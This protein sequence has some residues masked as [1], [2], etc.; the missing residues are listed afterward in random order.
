M[1]PRRDAGGL[2]QVVALSV[3]THRFSSEEVVI[4]SDVFAWVKPGDIVALFPAD[5]RR[6]DRLA[7]SVGK[8]GV[9]ASK[10]GV[11]TL[12]VSVLKSIA[13]RFGLHSMQQVVVSQIDPQQI[14]LDSLQLTFDSQFLSR[15]VL[16]RI[17]QALEGKC[18]YRGQ[19]LTVL[20]HKLRVQHMF[21]NG[22]EI[23]SG[24][25][26]S[27]TKVNFR[28][29]SARIIWLVQMS[30]EMWDF[31]NDGDIFFEKALKTFFEPCFERWAKLNAKHSLTVIFYT[32]TI[33][34][35]HSSALSLNRTMHSSSNIGGNIGGNGRGPGGSGLSSPLQQRLRKS[36]IK[37]KRTGCLY[38]DLFYVVVENETAT[39]WSS[40]I[41][42]LKKAFIAF[43]TLANWKL[44]PGSRGGSSSSSSSSRRTRK[45]RRSVAAGG[46]DNQQ[47]PKS[48][49]SGNGIGCGLP[50]SAANGNFFEALN[51]ALNIFDKHH[52]DRD[53]TRTG[54]ALVVIS[55]GMGL[56]E[57][58]RK[59]LMLTKRRLLDNGVGIDL[60]C[61]NSRPLH[62]VP[63]IIYKEDNDA[64][65]QGS[66]DSSAGQMYYNIPHWLRISFPAQPEPIGDD[67]SPLPSH[68]MI[69][70][71]PGSNND[72]GGDKDDDDDGVT[73]IIACGRSSV[74]VPSTLRAFLEDSSENALKISSA[75]SSSISSV[76]SL[77]GADG[78]GRRN[79]TKSTKLRKLAHVYR[80]V[81]APQPQ[82]AIAE[83]D[84]AKQLIQ[85][86]Q[87]RLNL[88]HFGARAHGIIPRPFSMTQMS[89]AKSR[90]SRGGGSGHVDGSSGG[91][92]SGS[93]GRMSQ[94]EYQAHD[95]KEFSA[96][97]Y[98]EGSSSSG[99]YSGY[100]GYGG[101]MSNMSTGTSSGGGGG[102]TGIGG[103]G[104]GIGSGI[105]GSGMGENAAIMGSASFQNLSGARLMKAGSGRSSKFDPRS[106][107]RANRVS[108][109]RT[110]HIGSYGD[111]AAAAAVAAGGGNENPVSNLARSLQRSDE[112]GGGGSLAGSRNN[113]GSFALGAP[114]TGNIVRVQS[115]TIK[116]GATL[117]QAIPKVVLV[118]PSSSWKEPGDGILSTSFPN[119]K[120]LASFMHLTK[121]DRLTMAGGKP[122]A[123]QEVDAMHTHIYAN[124]SKNAGMTRP[125]TN[126]DTKL[127][128]SV[129][130]ASDSPCSSPT[131]SPSPYLQALR[132]SSPTRDRFGSPPRSPGGTFLHNRSPQRHHPSVSITPL[133]LGSAAQLAEQSEESAGGGRRSIRR[134]LGSMRS[135]KRFSSERDYTEPIN[136]FKQKKSQ[137]EH[138]SS[139]RRRWRHLYTKAFDAL[140]GTGLLSDDPYALD[141]PSLSSPAILPL[142]TDYFP[143]ETV[144]NLEYSITQ[145]YTQCIPDPDE[146]EEMG[147]TSD[148][149]LVRELVCQRLAQDFQI[150]TAHDGAG[151]KLSGGLKYHLMFRHI[152]HKLTFD[153]ASRNIE[154]TI[155]T[156]IRKSEALSAASVYYQ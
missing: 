30:Q 52:M 76:S 23:T 25:V 3:H 36:V 58:D 64:S 107:S 50:S 70:L 155:Y 98:K 59:L 153:A 93:G 33:L 112:G 151:E 13:D 24:L 125:T 115:N 130:S 29:R 56:F 121:A 141:W 15:S 127:S 51:L 61:L 19:R 7:L 40:L 73:G 134:P 83:A 17:S 135:S 18:L 27:F 53:L 145:Q 128:S 81:T 154:V 106:T 123:M 44:A 117:Q 39:P 86:S 149:E 49:R 55:P 78:G 75:F 87:S 35:H 82:A 42:K 4:N 96:P 72:G 1:D 65:S 69:D 150:I 31:A 132:S 80:G 28:S 2:R 91:G 136:P 152:I 105:G 103:G 137:V 108:W 20:G 14:K 118:K 139:S 22:A 26:E 16:W 146:L 79:S 111:T 11:A 46:E 21:L 100:S 147:Y 143:T 95:M 114:T 144:L 67:F 113:S 9:Q 43:P 138:I 104:G 90:T 6:T 109:R 5:R 133:R 34:N 131:Q 48:S 142:T 94:L 12:K 77:F 68:R 119:E 37:D 85:R 60:L 120:E 99:G 101:G 126:V 57:A 63:L 102:G 10:H 148:E 116:W 97:R 140:R 84:D 88:S 32:R 62:R 89:A 66:S 38:E 45:N 71:L 129:N 122:A 156:H 124:M 8:A 54:Q 41:L 74:R 47:Q 110:S 92:G